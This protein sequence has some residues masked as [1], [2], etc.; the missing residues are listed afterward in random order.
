MKVFL[1]MF[2]CLIS[3]ANDINIGYS[4]NDSQGTSS[5]TSQTISLGLDYQDDINVSSFVLND[6]VEGSYSLISQNNIDSSD[7]VKLH[8]VVKYYDTPTFG[9]YN[10]VKVVIDSVNDIRNQ[11]IV[12]FGVLKDFNISSTSVETKMGLGY[13]EQHT[14]SSINKGTLV[15]LG[16][17]TQSK[18]TDSFSVKSKVDYYNAKSLDGFESDIKAI[19]KI[20][21][22]LDLIVE[23]DYSVNR[24]NTVVFTSSNVITKLSYKF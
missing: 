11:N 10:K 21:N 8:N 16:F 4:R 6:D 1:L 14:D 15:D 7:I 23:F 13:I 12:T 3:Y 24:V 5:Q 20:N 19:N 17:M 9:V 22:R 18:I 2:L